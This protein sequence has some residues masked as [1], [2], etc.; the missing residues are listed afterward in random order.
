MKKKKGFKVL[1]RKKVSHLGPEEHSGALEH[2]LP[3]NLAQVLGHDQPGPWEPILQREAMGHLK[4]KK[5]KKK[6]VCEHHI[7]PIPPITQKEEKKNVWCSLNK[8]Q[9]KI[10]F[11]LWFSRTILTRPWSCQIL[12]VSFVGIVEGANFVKGFHCLF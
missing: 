4:K 10:S 5:R 1:H 11:T 6:S 7:H 12:L 9:S 8:N 2:V 3:K